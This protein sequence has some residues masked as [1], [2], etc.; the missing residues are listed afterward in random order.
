M[1]D[2]TKEKIVIF[3]KRIHLYKPIVK[4]INTFYTIMGEKWVEKAVDKQEKRL[5]KKVS[6]KVDSIANIISSADMRQYKGKVYILQWSFFDKT[7]E[8]YISGGGERYACDLANL[9]GKLG[10]KVF[11]IQI[12]DSN[13]EHAWQKK[14][15]DM[16][17]IG[18]NASMSEY[19]KIIEMLPS[20]KLSIY[21]GYASWGRKKLRSPNILISHGITWDSPSS[22]ANTFALKKILDGADM[23]VSVDTNTISWLRT[24]YAASLHE[25]KKRMIYIPDYT[26]LSVYHPIEQNNDKIKIV[27]PRRCSPERGF[28]LISDIL[29]SILEKYKNV[30][31]EYVGFIHTS[32]I[33]DKINELMKMFPERVSHRLVSADKMNE[34]Y[35]NADIS[36]IPT[37]YCEG[38]SLS[39][40]EAM[41]CG[42]AVIAT[43]IGGLPNLIINDFN[44]MLINPDKDELLDAIEKVI[45]DKE[46]RKKLR[47]NALEVSKE[48]SKERWEERWSRLLASELG[49]Q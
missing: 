33:E 45:T 39:C 32:D 21:S 2:N 1:S 36:L 27:F 34:V 24:T 9:I 35:Q 11:L 3:L 40:I 19:F 4:V 49:I 38:T 6:A 22:D 43:N 29:P 48:F 13:C 8:K 30:Y 5:E 14:M 12:G 31:F 17:V 47:M 37:L 44:G 7:G 28:W 10:Y 18:V 46:Y 20:P 16:T 42:N 41:A 26:D 25:N 15:Y 23:L